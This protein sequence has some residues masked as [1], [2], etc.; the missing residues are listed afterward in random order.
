[1]RH[2]NLT[3]YVEWMWNY[4][5]AVRYG[6]ISAFTESVSSQYDLKQLLAFRET[7]LLHIVRNH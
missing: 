2:K 3:K 7:I 6:I 4:H 1:M 5:I